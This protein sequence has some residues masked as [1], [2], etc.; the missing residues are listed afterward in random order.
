MKS[1][2]T[3]FL[4]LAASSLMT[5]SAQTTPS[6]NVI[7]GDLNGV[8]NYSVDTSLGI[9]AF[10][11]GT[12]SCNIGDAPLSWVSGNN[13]HPVIAQHAYRMKDGRFEQIGQSWL[14][15]GFFALSQTLCGTCPNPSNGTYLAEGCSD[16]YSSG[17]NGSQGGLGPKFEVNAFTG[18]FSYPFTDQGMTGSSIYKRLQ[19]KTTDLDPALNAGALYFV[20]GQY[21]TQDD[22][23]AG[24]GTDNVSWREVSVSGSN[25][26]N[27]SFISGKDTQRQQ[28]AIMAWAVNDPLVVV[29]PADVPGE[30][31]FWVGMRTAPMAGGGYSFDFAV[32]NINSDRS[33]MGFEVDF[34]A[35]AT[36]TNLSFHDVDYHSGEPFD[37]TDWTGTVDNANNKVR[38]DGVT[39]ATNPNGNAIRWGNLF[40]FHFE[41]D[42]P[43]SAT[44][45]ARIILFKPGTPADVTVP[46][47]PIGSVTKVAGE[48]QGANVGEDFRQDLQVLV[49]DGFGNPVV[50][51]A[52]VFTTVSGNAL[53][54]GTAAALTDSNGIATHALR[55][56]T[57]PSTSTI[58][59]V[60]FSTGATTT[61]TVH[62]RRFRTFWTPANGTILFY[63]ETERPGMY[64]TLAYD[65]PQAA[66]PTPWG[67]IYTSILS[68]GFDF[69]AVSGTGTIGIYDP[70]LVTNSVG[71]CIVSYGG[72]QNLA[73]AGFT[74]VFQMY[75]YYTD[76]LGVGQYYISEPNYVF[77]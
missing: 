24:N 35:G 61:F 42:T 14:K 60:R 4:C 17:L 52:V 31:R 37:G 47:E 58:E 7:V 12:T 77:F 25:D 23:Q 49:I 28:P 68:P 54:P 11:V 76:S 71:D 9:D 63:A 21:V 44:L 27:M 29:R 16:P 56:A 33:A 32:Q 57:S 20:E 2:L 5:L 26:Y 75:G 70:A 36:I 69:G 10:S 3:V 19:V 65:A 73:G 22:A 66:L 34:P 51:E 74:A 48:D 18:V 1:V 15:H 39:F 40:S 6:P 45:M 50:G 72:N 67:N 43:I 59:A 46:L 8:S 30:G 13:L 62:T 53:L 64:L 41:S 55:A 38:W